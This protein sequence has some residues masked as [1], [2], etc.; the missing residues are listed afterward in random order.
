MLDMAP[1]ADP[2]DETDLLVFVDRL[3]AAG[4]DRAGA[5]AHDRVRRAVAAGDVPPGLRRIAEGVT[6]GGSGE[7]APAPRRPVDD[8]ASVVAA[9][10]DHPLIVLDGAGPDEVASAVSALLSDGRRVILTARDAGALATVRATLPD[11]VADRVVD[12]LPTLPPARLHRLRGLLATSTPERRARPQQ[13][14]PDLAVLPDPAEID[15]LCESATRRAAEGV[16]LV[17]GLLAD[18][19]PDRRETVTALAE[20]VTRALGALGNREEP[21]T[22]D[23]LADLVQ[24]RHRSAFDRLVQVTAHAL[25]VIEEGA[26]D[27]PVHVAA[28]LQ[29]EDIDA[30]TAYLEFLKAGGRARSYFRSPIQREVE[31]VLDLIRVDDHE[32]R[33]ARDLHIVHTH[34]ELQ[35]QL[36]AVDAA[37][38]DLDLPT[39]EGAE[40]LARLAEVLGDIATAARAVAGLRHDMLFLRVD[41]PVAVPDVAGAEQLA[42]AI[43]DHAENGSPAEAARRLDGLAEALA[44]A[45]PAEATAPEHARAVAALRARDAQAYAAAVDELVGAQRE[46]RDELTAA[47]LLAELGAESPSLAAAWAPAEGRPLQLGLVWPTPVERLLEQL[48]P[49][50]RADVVVVLDAGSAGVDRALL[51]AAAPRMVAVAAPGD[52]AD[53][54]TLLDL[55]HRASALVIRGR[56]GENLIEHAAVAATAQGRVVPLPPGARPVPVPGRG[57][58]E[59]AGA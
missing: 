31:P 8:P 12:A 30:L 47:E 48:P 50:D 34:L 17:A 58:V 37:C 54:P 4:T 33:T 21:W 27:P 25:A 15:R 28:P 22:W 14:L 16:E 46:Q 51:A 23:L 11:T 3:A 40:Q 53:G 38:S 13:Q 29:P 55:L 26:G 41:S 6:A 39:P 1:G 43:L 56:A 9:V 52:T 36:T 10:R 5:R 32:P 59:Q 57:E 45:A 19:E 35:E 24:G 18:L 42:V 7:L 2:G 44:A 20:A 49:P